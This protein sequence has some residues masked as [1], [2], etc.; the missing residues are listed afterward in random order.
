MHVVPAL[1]R[2]P[3]PDQPGRHEPDHEE[4]AGADAALTMSGSVIIAVVVWRHDVDE[5]LPACSA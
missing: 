5:G 4:Q 1:V 3:P 2:H